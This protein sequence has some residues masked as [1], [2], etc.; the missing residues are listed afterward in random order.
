MQVVTKELAAAIHYYKTY[1]DYIHISDQ[2]YPATPPD[3]Q[4]ACVSHLSPIYWSNTHNITPTM[5]A[6]L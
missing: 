2:Y 1:I 3:E 6:T 5:Q 4:Y